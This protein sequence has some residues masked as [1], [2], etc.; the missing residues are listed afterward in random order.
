MQERLE[1]PRFGHTARVNLRHAGNST[2]Y[3]SVDWAGVRRD[4]YAA[5]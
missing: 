2:P 5:T 3:R 4:L 1:R